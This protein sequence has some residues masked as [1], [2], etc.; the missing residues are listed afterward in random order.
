M[1]HIFGAAM[2]GDA[3]NS[4]DMRIYTTVF[5]VLT[6]AIVAATVLPLRRAL[7]LQ[8]SAALRHS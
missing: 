3:G 1:A 8:P 4:H 2:D 7:Q 6:L 5:M